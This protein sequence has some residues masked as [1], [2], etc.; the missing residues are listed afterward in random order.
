MV[1]FACRVFALGIV[2]VFFCATAVYAQE[3]PSSEHS[4]SGSQ[5]WLPHV[6]GS[7]ILQVS[8]QLPPPAPAYEVWLTDQNNTA[9]FSAGTPRGTHGG[10]ILIYDGADLDNPNGPLNQP[11][12]LDLATFYA[13]TGPNNNTGANVVRPHMA[14]PSP[15]HNYVAVA[16]VASGHVAI[17]G[18]KPARVPQRHS[19]A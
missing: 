18:G 15:D 4:P 2:T 12:I 5:I 11:E 1:N 16:F 7:T 19:S 9:G 3:R 17:I 6:S 14:I 10:R 8:A 13:V